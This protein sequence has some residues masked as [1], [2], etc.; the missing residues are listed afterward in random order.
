[1]FVAI[2]KSTTSG[3][4][5]FDGIT[6]VPIAVTSGAYLNIKVVNPHLMSGDTLTINNGATLTVN[7]D[8]KRFLAGASAVAVTNGT[9]NITNSST[10]TPIRFATG[11]LAT[12]SAL[13]SIAASTGLSKVIVQGA[14][15]TLSGTSS[16]AAGQ[17]FTSPYATGDYIPAL[18]VETGAG[19]N[20]WEIWTNVTG[21]RPFDQ[22]EYYRNGFRSVGAGD[23]GKCFTQ[24]GDPTACQYV[25]LANCNVIP[26]TNIA[27]CTSTAGLVPGT[28]LTG[29]GLAATAVVQEV[30][31]STTFS[32]NLVVP[33]A[34][35]SPTS[36]YTNIPMIGIRPV[37]SQFTTT[38]RFGDGVN[39][40]IPVTG[41]RIKIPNIMLTDY[42]SAVF[43]T[44]VYSSTN[45]PCNFTTTAGGVF[46][47]DT[48]LFGE[49]Y[50][51]CNQSGQW[52]FN[53][54]G[55]AY[56]PF[57]SEGYSTT[58]TNTGFGLP[59]VTMH[60]AAA[61]A[62]GATGSTNST[63]TVTTPATNAII[64]GVLLTGTNLH[65]CTVTSIA[66]TTSLTVSTAAFGTA[67][68]IAFSYYGP[69]TMRDHRMNLGTTA[70][71]GSSFTAMIWQYMSNFTMTNC[72]MTFGGHSVNGT[73]TNPGLGGVNAGALNFQYS[74][75]V[76]IDGLKV[77]AVGS[78]PK[79]RPNATAINAT[80]IGSNHTYNNIK[81]YNWSG[82][83]GAYATSNINVSNI[84]HRT[85]INN[86][87]YG[88]ASAYKIFTDP[89][90][91]AFIADNTKYWIKTRSY[92]TIDWSDTTGYADGV[93]MCGVVSTPAKYLQMPKK[94]GA[95]PAW[96]TAISPTLAY[97]NGV[98]VVLNGTVGALAGNVMVSA[99]NGATWTSQTLPIMAATYAWWKV[100]FCSASSMFVAIGGGTAASTMAAYSVN[101]LDWSSVTTAPASA[102]WQAI[103]YDNTQASNKIVGVSGGS[104][105]STA[106][107][108]ATITNG[109]IVFAA[110]TLASAQWIDVASNSTGRF[111]AIAGG[112]AVGTA[113]AYSTNGSSWTSGGA[114][115]SSLWQ[116]IAYGN[117]TFC[118]ISSSSTTGPTSCSA[119]AVA[120]TA[121]TAPA[122]PTGMSYNNILYTGSVFVLFAGPTPL[123]NGAPTLATASSCYCV[124]TANTATSVTWGAL[125][126][127]PDC[128]YWIGATNNGNAVGVVSTQTGK[129][130]YT[131]D[132]TA[133]TPTWTLSTNIIP[134]WNRFNLLSTVQEYT[135]AL[136]T[137]SAVATTKDS[138][139]VTCTSTVMIQVGT[140]MTL[141][142]GNCLAAGA[143]YFGTGAGTANQT[144]AVIVVSIT[145]ATTFVINK[146]ALKTASGMTAT[147]YKHAY[148]LY[149]ST[150]PGFTTRDY[151][152]LVGSTASSGSGNLMYLDDQMNLTPG[153]TYY[154]RLRKL[155][156]GGAVNLTCSGTAAAS[157]IT[158][159]APLSFYNWQTTREL[160]G[161]SGTNV[162]SS[163]FFNFFVNGIVPGCIVTGVGIPAGTTV[164]DVP[165]FDTIVLSANLTSDINDRGNNRTLVRFSPAPGMYVFNSNLGNDCKIVSIDSATQITVDVANTNTFSAQSL[166]FV[167]GAELPEIACIPTVPVVTTNLA[168][169]S[170]T[171]ATAPWT[172][173]GITVTA[174]S[175]L[176]PIDSFVGINAAA[177]T[178]T[179]CK[180]VRTGAT[181]T[182]T[183]IVNTGVGS[184]YTFSIYARAEHPDTRSYLQM[185]LSFGT[186]SQTFT[187]TNQWARYYVT[188]TTTAAT[189]NA[190]ITLPGFG[191]VVYA[192]NAMVTLGSTPPAPIT[193]TTTTPVYVAPQQ[194]VSPTTG[195]IMGWQNTD[196]GIELTI[197][198]WA[199]SNIF[200]TVHV[201]S[202]SDFTPT[203]QNQVFSSEAPQASDPLFGVSTAASNITIDNY[204]PD[205]Q[206]IPGHQIVLLATTG[207]SGV[208]IKNSTFA[209]N[210]SSGNLVGSSAT[211]PNYNMYL[212][213]LNIIN[214]KSYISG[215]YLD[216]TGANNSS[217]FKY[218][219]IRSNRASKLA[220]TA[221]SSSTNFKGV[222]GGNSY[223][224]TSAASWNLSTS[225]ALDSIPI[226][227]TGVY[228]AMFH[229][230]TWG[231]QAKGCLDIR[232]TKS[233]SSSPPYTITSGTPY[234]SNDGNL[235]LQT[236][237][238]QMVIEWPHFI[239][240]ITGFSE[241]MPHIYSTDLGLSVVSS[242][243]VK[244]EYDLNRG[245]GYT[246]SWKTLNGSI[247]LSNLSTEAA[248]D[249]D[250]GVRPKFRLTAQKGLKYTGQL[251]Q[252]VPGWTI[253]NAIVNPTAT[254]IVVADE[255]TGAATT[256]TITVS[257]V[258]GEWVTT[259]TLYSGTL[260]TT[261]TNTTAAATATMLTSS[262]SGT[263]LT[264]G[265]VSAGT[266][267]VGMVLT[268]TGVVAGTYIISGSGLSWQ[269]ANPNPLAGSLNV[270]S[271]T[272]TGTNNVIT[273]NTTANMYV[274]AAM[275]FST[276]TGGITAATTYYVSCVI[277]ATHFCLS[278]SFLGTSNITLT[279]TAVTTYGVGYHATITATNGYTFFPQPTS[280]INSI[281]IFT[282]T[283]TGSSHNYA[284][285]TPTLTLTGLQPGSDIVVLNAGS[286]IERINIDNN[287]GTTYAYT[288]SDVGNVDIGVFKAGYI[289]FYIRNYTL[290]TTNASLPVVQV[291]DRAY[292]NA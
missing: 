222:P 170:T 122:L 3:A 77:I 217:G 139:T 202:T 241:R 116:A 45:S 211:L 235:F 163:L 51:Q 10:T 160:E 203:D 201:G 180:L 244:V 186:A 221:Q 110:S 205:N 79:T 114:L 252:F 94:F 134:V 52:S 49:S 232:M 109:S 64:P 246:G 292:S 286:T 42:T 58:F 179:G 16:G 69:W 107:T 167:V 168:L 104:A 275:Q 128:T 194:V 273:C 284:F 108:Y 36:G 131:P 193:A 40:A 274:G 1:M 148:Q 227:N 212:H 145:N 62:L 152:T 185:T 259:N 133:A 28:W 135:T 127:L 97:G 291:I 209:F 106:G 192:Q 200:A 216:T 37:S 276:T 68:S 285:S 17:T 61:T 249:P 288:Y 13:H 261:V 83:F 95:Q 60:V 230:F 87:G 248:V 196:G 157:T 215:W 91:N 191:T 9:L 63:T 7:T 260:K 266:V 29:R 245:S 136:S 41:A 153:T 88:L 149:R 253:Q 207:C 189:T 103:A 281:R 150:T 72:V 30:I 99:D 187:L 287:S 84:I 141:S 219:N 19:T 159:A 125:K 74:N 33:A 278:A 204:Q 147:F 236:P 119:D 137:A 71:A 161:K 262:I 214:P 283:D 177:P 4:F 272:I 57:I 38:L 26:D 258:T 96:S 11:R 146:P 27:T 225:V 39:G 182:L 70:A 270:A 165:D 195:G 6:W 31:N 256:G 14:F 140:V 277:D 34:T 66:S 80:N 290:L 198:N 239:K 22:Y 92:K 73:N 257:D 279:T 183:Q 206:F 35:A 93:P 280:K 267:A 158:C 43:Q 218:Q 173:A 178:A 90:N 228:D 199:P 238:D 162:L 54:V 231:N 233:T 105:A 101:G 181:G 220:W 250:T 12:T 237:G 208:N 223:P 142:A 115:A 169:Q 129:F 156:G 154:Y 240:G 111:V 32:M 75:N 255:T 15:I 263:T 82:V 78:Y 289:P 197:A 20:V 144:N 48:C 251:G 166:R 130:A 175:Q 102:I 120:W 164:I 25:Q 124:S 56:V 213:N 138:T 121:G 174:A 226:T 76:N 143:I 46:Q 85:G 118:A 242:L 269:V 132:I 47:F 5:S 117:G 81:L 50:S 2:A 100:M 254:A 229:E 224:L 123:T 112:S 126:Y 86:E 23:G 265:S 53:N 155:S 247:G 67:G 171:L 210:G 190:V 21:S 282:E 234:F 8:Q 55:A 271:T 172:A 65:A 176:G 98:W 243:G 268:G 184:A 18:W 24:D 44:A 188:F 151:T 89:E 113:S 264:I 59:P